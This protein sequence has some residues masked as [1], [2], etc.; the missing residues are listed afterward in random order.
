[1]KYLVFKLGPARFSIYSIS[2]DD[3]AQEVWSVIFQKVNFDLPKHEILSYMSSIAK[4]HGQRVCA[5]ALPIKVPVYLFFTIFKANCRNKLEDN[6]EFLAAP[7]NRFVV[8]L[9]EDVP[10]VIE[11]GFRYDYLKGCLGELVSELSEKERLIIGLRFGPESYTLE[12]IGEVLGCTKQYVQQTEEVIIRKLRVR[13]LESGVV[14]GVDKERL[15][16]LPLPETRSGSSERLVPSSTLNT[17]LSAYGC[18]KN[19]FVAVGG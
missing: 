19:N 18:K 9:E 16:R 3:L 1:M 12:R 2:D 4:T 17:K 15:R 8:P 13:L 11:D 14:D 7:R 6:W 5:R 10:E